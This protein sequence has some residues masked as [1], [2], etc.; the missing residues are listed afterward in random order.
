MT[1]CVT[2]S[3]TKNLRSSFAWLGGFTSSKG[4]SPMILARTAARKNCLA[5]FTVRPAVPSA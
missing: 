5:R 2:S 3:V 1:R 4:F